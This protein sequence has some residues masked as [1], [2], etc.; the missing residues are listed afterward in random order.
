MFVPLA[1]SFY[2]ILYFPASVSDNYKEIAPRWLF[3]PVFYRENATCP[4]AP[5]SNM[6]FDLNQSYPGDVSFF[7]GRSDETLSMLE[8]P[9]SLRFTHPLPYGAILHDDGVQFVVVSRSATAMRVLAYDKVRDR[10]PSELIDFDPSL[11]RWGDIWSVFV[12]G[13]GAGQLY[14]FQADGPY[15]PEHGYRFD[16]KA[17]LIDPYAKALAGHFQSACDGIIRPPKCVVMD[18]DFNWQ[19]DRHIRRD[20]SETIIYELHVRGFTRS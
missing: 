3:S 20:L 8:H 6:V 5:E 16:S 17:R 4:P 19:G 9:P 18:E 12:P 14:H 10:E 7:A 15:D 1:A 2:L 11:N 13:M